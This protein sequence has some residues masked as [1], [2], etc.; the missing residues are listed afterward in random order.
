MHI[1]YVVIG[2]IYGVYVFMDMWGFFAE[3]WGPF[4]TLLGFVPAM[5]IAVAS[6]AT[7]PVAIL[8]DW[9]VL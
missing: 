1:I 2:I 7:W 6:A 8:L 5:I 9:L 3:L 4:G